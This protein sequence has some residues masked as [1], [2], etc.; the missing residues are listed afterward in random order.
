MPSTL[1]VWS[2]SWCSSFL[3]Y[4]FLT[5]SGLGLV[6]CFG[7]WDISKW[8][9]QACTPSLHVITAESTSS[10]G[11]AADHHSHS[12]VLWWDTE[13]NL[14]AIN[15]TK[16]YQ[17]KMLAFLAARAWAYDLGLT[18][19]IQPPQTL[20]TSDTKKWEP[21]RIHFGI[22]GWLEQHCKLWSPV[23]SEDGSSVLTRIVW[24]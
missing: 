3:T 7:Q 12:K 20:G 14:S 10:W 23:L 21:E 17:I 1:P 19:Q 5:L 16:K 6:T 22:A 24:V 4:P 8:H 9:K 18:H 11:T 15:W 2:L 13:W